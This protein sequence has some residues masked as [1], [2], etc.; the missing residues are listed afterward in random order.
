MKN[1]FIFFLIFSLVV[2]CLPA[3]VEKKQE[4]GAAEEIDLNPVSDQDYIYRPEGRRDPFWNLLMGKSV[5]G[6]REKI[7]G[8]AGLIIDEVELEGVIKER[9]KFKALLKGPDG[10]PYIVQIGDKLYDGEIVQITANSV[11]FRRV[12]T[13][14]IGGEREKII[15]KT[16]NPEEEEKNQ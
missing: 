11:S 4:A 9:G 3:Q 1:R 6:S 15:V 2:I 12:L 16:I 7:E 14:A 10:Q 5:R 13:V 8:I